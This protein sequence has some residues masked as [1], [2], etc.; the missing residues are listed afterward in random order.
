MLSL[1]DL[2]GPGWFKPDQAANVTHVDGRNDPVGNGGGGEQMLLV[3][4]L[5]SL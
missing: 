1:G 5:V 2:H 3:R 4:Q